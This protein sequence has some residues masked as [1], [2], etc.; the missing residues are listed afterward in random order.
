M[1][2]YAGD[3]RTCI[4]NFETNQYGPNCVKTILE[5]L[6]FLSQK[7]VTHGDIKPA[8]ILFDR[9]ER[10]YL[11]DFGQIGTFDSPR[12][13]VISEH[14]AAPEAYQQQLSSKSDIWSLGVVVLDIL[15]K[16]PDFPPPRIG[17]DHREE[18]HKCITDI[19]RDI[20]CLPRMLSAQ[21]ARRDDAATCLSQFFPKDQGEWPFKEISPVDIDMETIVESK[22]AR[23]N[24]YRVS[25]GRRKGK[26]YK[27]LTR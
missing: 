21:P 2:L 16:R 13:Y 23:K 18:Y 22:R 9:Q 5:V 15:K 6:A 8:N 25:K 19:V 1:H 24:P 3:L 27:G 7:G 10:F 11:T 12:G 20:S 26:K 14:Y 4:A 17:M